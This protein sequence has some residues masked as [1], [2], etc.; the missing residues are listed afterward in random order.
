MTDPVD[1]SQ[2]YQQMLQDLVGDADPLEVLDATAGKVESIVARVEEGTLHKRPAE[3]AWSVAEVIGH[4]CDTEW[5]YGYR[6]RLMLSHPEPP[7]PGYD[8]DLMTAGLEHNERHVRQMLAEFRTLRQLNVKLYWRARGPAWERV[9]VHEERGPESVGLNI[10]LT[11]GHDLLH[12]RQIERT[13]AAVQE[14]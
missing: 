9:G 8:Q 11:A 4:L 13:L 3:D 12:L 7:I 10:S 1:Q 14:V 6:V 5:V 2:E